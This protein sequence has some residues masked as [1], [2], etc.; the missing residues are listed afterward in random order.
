MMT[1]LGITAV[2]RASTSSLTPG[3]VLRNRSM[4]TQDNRLNT[5][6][7]GSIRGIQSILGQP[8]G[9]SP[10]SSN[11]SIEGRVSPSPS[12]AASAHEV[13]ST[14]SIIL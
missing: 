14:N 13:R 12:F 1:P 5:F 6:K 9:V 2:A 3:P 4:R 7:R 10:Y 8:P 11:S